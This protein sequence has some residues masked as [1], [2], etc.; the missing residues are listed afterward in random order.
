MH[1]YAYIYLQAPYIKT[2]VTFLPAVFVT[3]KL[4][5]MFTQ[6]NT[7]NV[8]LIYVSF[9]PAVWVVFFFIQ[10]AM[11]NGQAETHTFRVTQNFLPACS[12]QISFR[13]EGR[14][15]FSA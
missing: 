4:S 13:S 12:L 14:L 2:M 9:L 10:Y 6:L 5:K 8:R 11:P 15:C 3:W 1:I 7:E